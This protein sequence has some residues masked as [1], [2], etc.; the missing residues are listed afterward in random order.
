MPTRNRHNSIVRHLYK[1]RDGVE[2]RALAKI[3]FVTS[4]EDEGAL[5][6]HILKADRN[7]EVILCDPSLQMP[8][9]IVAQEKPELI[10]ME[11]K[12]VGPDPFHLCQELQ[13]LSEGEDTP[14]LFWRVATTPE[15]FYP[16]V[17]ELG[18]AGYLG[19]F[20]RPEDLV[21]ARDIVLA[22]VDIIQTNKDEIN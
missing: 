4:S 5:L 19:Y 6:Q 22:G 13:A 3:V 11:L 12:L 16:V 8:V 14:I 18:I 9:E 20:A 1:T 21:E 7:D 10:L 17:Q 2:K 15:E